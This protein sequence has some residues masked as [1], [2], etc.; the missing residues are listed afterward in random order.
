[1]NDSVIA[2]VEICKNLTAEQ[3]EALTDAFKGTKDWDSRR[4][5]SL[6]VTFA[7]LSRYNIPEA[8]FERL[9]A[10]WVLVMGRTW[11]SA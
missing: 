8:V 2:H 5:A 10:P 4:D 11:E 3:I 9:V 7:L 6:D 1:M